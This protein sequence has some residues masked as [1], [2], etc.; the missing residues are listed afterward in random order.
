MPKDNALQK[1]ESHEKLC[2][3]MQKQTH[4]KIKSLEQ[5]ITRIERILLVSVGALITGMAGVILVLIEKL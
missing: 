3:I 1:I 4:D 2:R 5:Q